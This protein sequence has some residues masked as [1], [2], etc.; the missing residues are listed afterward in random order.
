MNRSSGIATTRSTETT[1]APTASARGRGAPRST[2]ASS[3]DAEKRG[4]VEHV[5]LL[6]PVGKLRREYG[7]DQDD[8]HRQGDRGCEERL[9]PRIERARPCDE[10]DRGRERDH[11]QVEGELGYVPPEVPECFAECVRPLADGLIGAEQTSSRDGLECESSESATGND[12]VQPPELSERDHEAR[13]LEQSEDDG[14]Q[15]DRGYE[16]DGLHASGVRQS[17]EEQ[18][19]CY[20][21]Q[22]RSLEH[23]HQNES[24]QEEERIERVLRHDGAR[25]RHGRDRHRHERPEQREPVPHD[26][27]GEE[28][29][30]YRSKGHHQRV[31]RLH[32]RVR[33]HQ[34]VRQR[35][36]RADQQRVDD[37]VAGVGLV[38]QERLAG[39]C[40]PARHLGPDDLVDHDERRDEISREDRAHDRRAGHDGREP[41]PDRNPAE[42]STQARPRRGGGRSLSP[43]PSSAEM[44]TSA[45]ASLTSRSTA[46]STAPPP[47]ALSSADG[48]EIGD[49]IDVVLAESEVCCCR[50]HG[51]ANVGT[52]GEKL[53][54]CRQ[55]L[56]LG[57]VGER[58]S[59]RR[60]PAAP[61]TTR[62]HSRRAASRA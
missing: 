8:R 61:R 5:P 24:D 36:D 37:A 3:S 16:S 62:R 57:V 47:T 38:A 1:A 29:G 44:P 11:E 43:R 51:L 39:I 12:P 34:A 32:A 14:R 40:D 59:M 30:G 56:D 26:S 35:V 33:V 2:H 27:T 31:E 15:E 7:Y 49:T 53:E 17:H 19:Q 4:N 18:K 23:D 60:P 13:P 55:R 25:V 54:R 50:A 28:E 9:E 46:S 42:R 48:V 20:E 22:R 45:A 6:D 41:R 58:P 21:E 10:D 52:R